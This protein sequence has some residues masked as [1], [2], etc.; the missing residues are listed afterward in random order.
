MSAVISNEYDYGDEVYVEMEIRD[1]NSTP[2]ANA[3]I[4]P[5]TL[6]MKTK[7]PLGVVTTYT[8]PDSIA[9]TKTGTG[10]FSFHFSA[11][12]EGEW[13]YRM[14]T[15]GTG[16]GAEEKKIIVKDSAFYSG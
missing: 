13:S 12:M 6:V 3:L 4:D 15:T 7:N 14:E 2:T 11:D 8:Y 10:L 16:K 9:I 5:T 1:P